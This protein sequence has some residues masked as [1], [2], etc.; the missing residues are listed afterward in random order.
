MG[1]VGE[2]ALLELSLGKPGLCLSEGD[3]LGPRPLFLLKGMGRASAAASRKA[4]RVTCCGPFL[5]C[6]PGCSGMVSHTAN[7][8]H[9]G[10][11]REN[12]QDRDF[13]T[14]L[15]SASMSPPHHLGTGPTLG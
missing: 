5:L 13:G 14:K 10:E 1:L 12:I 11:S 4:K 7:Q 6:S 15:C 9:P 2:R 3:R 8:N